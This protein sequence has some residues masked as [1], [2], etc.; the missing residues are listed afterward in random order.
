MK[1][2]NQFYYDFRII[3]SNIKISIT[4]RFFVNQIKIDDCDSE[5][6]L[7]N[8]INLKERLFLTKYE[9]GIK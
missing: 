1:Y 7:K 3:I 9:E 4:L 6:I 8:L 5:N 2:K